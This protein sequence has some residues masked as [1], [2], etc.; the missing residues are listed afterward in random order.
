MPA[1]S[2]CGQRTFLAGDDLFIPSLL[3]IGVRL[4]QLVVL[5]PLTIFMVRDYI[6]DVVGCPEEQR[7]SLI[8]EGRKLAVS[9]VV[10]SYILV[11]V[12]LLLEVGILFSTGRGT[13]TQ[14]EKRRQVQRLCRWKLVPFSLLRVA[15]ITLGLI[16]ISIVNDYCRC[17]DETATALVLENECLHMDSN[18]VC[19]KILVG[20]QIAEA[21]AVVVIALYFGLKCAPSPPSFMSSTRKWQLCCHCFLTTSSLMTCGCFGGREVGD[22]NDISM[23]LADYFDN[24]GTLDIVPSDILVGMLML[25]RVQEQRRLQCREEL[26]CKSNEHVEGE[27]HESREDDTNIDPELAKLACGSHHRASLVYQMHRSGDNL[28]YLAEARSILSP[29]NAGD[30]IVIADGAPFARYARAMYTY[31]MDFLEKPIKAA[32]VF[33]SSAAKSLCKE[34]NGNVEGDN[35]CG[36]HEV[37]LEWWTGLDRDQIPHANFSEGVGVVPYCIAIDHTWKSVVIAIRGTQALEDLI[38][39]MTLRPVSM[40]ECATRCGFD[41]RDCYAHAG[42]LESSECIYS[43]LEKYVFR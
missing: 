16:L 15:A 29:K 10:V 14:P 2:V 18:E 38:T 39:D 11:I 43:Q 42:M 37:S 21:C 17:E 6:N 33:A 9:Y 3:F 20:T 35:V 4:L 5:I 19:Y 40:E 34:K 36:S 26:L 28:H 12:G 27:N 7:P 31:K 1:L 24:G 25:L 22:F 13:P 41:G 8:E 23:T 32:F 30:R